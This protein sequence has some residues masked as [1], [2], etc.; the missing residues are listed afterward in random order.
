M[1][2]RELLPRRPSS[3]RRGLTSAADSPAAS[4]A[5]PTALLERHTLWNKEEHFHNM[6]EHRLKV[7]DAQHRQI[8][9]TI[10]SQ[11][12]HTLHSIKAQQRLHDIMAE[13]LHEVREQHVQAAQEQLQALKQS[14]RLSGGIV[15][16]T[17][18]MPQQR[19]LAEA[20]TTRDRTAL[21]AAVHSAPR[22]PAPAV[23]SGG[24][25][26]ERQLS[27]RYCHASG[28]R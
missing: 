18:R 28:H 4:A 25:S 13:H 19:G 2:W 26:P 14:I 12:R 23:R 6:T 22:V 7:L 3:V 17:S 24:G 15:A 5:L 9:E 21:P 8:L 1:R 20:A 10:R 27:A 16:T 11:H